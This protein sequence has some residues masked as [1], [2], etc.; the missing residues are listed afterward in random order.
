MCAY[1]YIYIYTYIISIYI[2][3]Y[4]HTHRYTK[5][6]IHIRRAARPADAWAPGN[7]S[8]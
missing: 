3:I 2:Y 5:Q 4:I 7:G 1:I 6:L 8:R